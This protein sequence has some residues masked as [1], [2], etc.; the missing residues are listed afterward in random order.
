M[1]AAAVLIESPTYID[2]ASTPLRDEAVRDFIH[3]LRQPLSS[4]E[5]IAYYL[6]MTLPPEQMQARQYMRKLQQLVDEANSILHHAAV[7]VK[8]RG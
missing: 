4:I 1:S 5:A 7:D 8:V 2:T 3:D 6:E